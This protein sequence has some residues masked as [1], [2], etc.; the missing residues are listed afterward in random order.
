MKKI[1]NKKKK[2]VPP[3]GRFFDDFLSLVSRKR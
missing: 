2:I 1:I 3:F